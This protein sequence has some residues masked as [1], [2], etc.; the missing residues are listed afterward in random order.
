[1]EKIYKLR[2]KFFNNFGMPSNKTSQALSAD[3]AG[4]EEVLLP[5]SGFHLN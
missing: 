5:G 3:R 2:S 1:M 4:R